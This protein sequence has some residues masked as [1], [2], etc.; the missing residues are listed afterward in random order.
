MHLRVLGFLLALSALSIPQQA[1]ADPADVTFQ[2]D[3]SLPVEPDQPDSSNPR[4]S[5]IDAFHGSLGLYND[6][7]TTADWNVPPIPSKYAGRDADFAF[8]PNDNSGTANIYSGPANPLTYSAIPL[9]NQYG[10][11]SLV[12]TFTLPPI[13]SSET[14]SIQVL[15]TG[16][17]GKTITLHFHVRRGRGSGHLGL[18]GCLRFVLRCSL[19]VAVVSDRLGVFVAAYSRCKVRMIL[20]TCK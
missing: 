9:S 14:L 5:V 18:R 15:N 13:S 3:C 7:G 4:F 19:S 11:S 16:G 12:G 1:V 10:G 6:Q 2:L 17:T 8:V 20:S